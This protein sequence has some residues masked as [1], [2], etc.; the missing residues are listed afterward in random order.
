MIKMSQSSRDFLSEKYP[1][2]LTENDV[3]RFLL[4]LDALITRDGLDDKD[5]M[6]AFGHKLQGVYDE[7]YMCNE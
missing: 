6:T 4:K 7:V 2:I 1:E 5:N 3:D